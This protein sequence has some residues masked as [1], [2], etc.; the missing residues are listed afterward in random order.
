MTAPLST[1]PGF[2]RALAAVRGAEFGLLRAVALDVV[3][4]GDGDALPT[5]GPEVID[6]MRR[7]TGPSPVDLQA[8]ATDD[9]G[10]V[11][12]LGRA[13]RGIAVSAHLSIIAAERREHLRATIR[14]VGTHGSVLVDLLRPALDVRTAERSKRIAYG[15]AASGAAADDTAHILCA[16]AESARSGARISTTW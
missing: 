16:I 11:T 1:R 14:I 7:L 5:L 6:V 12:F 9:G 10:A 4:L 8:H 3:T 15:A 13:A 2:T